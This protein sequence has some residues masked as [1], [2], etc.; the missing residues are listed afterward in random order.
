MSK[1]DLAHHVARQY[2]T[3]GG[4]MLHENRLKAKRFEK[5]TSSILEID[6]SHKKHLENLK[7]L[8]RHPA[9]VLNADYQVRNL[10]DECWLSSFF[11]LCQ[12]CVCI[13]SIRT[14]RVCM[15]AT[16]YYYSAHEPFALELVELARCGK[17]CI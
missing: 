8:D 9:L 16:V 11:L 17:G 4:G 6:A 2:L 12:T 7:R 5:Q 3:G 10:N 15:Y 1:Q 14:Y 13:C